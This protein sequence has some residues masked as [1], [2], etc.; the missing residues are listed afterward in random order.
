VHQHSAV[1]YFSFSHV[2][3]VLP[4]VLSLFK[5]TTTRIYNIS[6][7]RCFQSS[8]TDHL[9]FETEESVKGENGISNRKE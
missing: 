5:N 3:N 7:F 1:F 8:A 2:Y 6:A 4:T 9:S